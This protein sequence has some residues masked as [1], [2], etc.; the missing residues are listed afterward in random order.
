MD[1]R[2]GSDTTEIGRHLV[3]DAGDNLFMSGPVV[4]DGTTGNFIVP[5]AV[6]TSGSSFF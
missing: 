2:Y 6:G 4:Y 1:K 3:I 5:A